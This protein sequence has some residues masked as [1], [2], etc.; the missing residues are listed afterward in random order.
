MSGPAYVFL[1]PS[2][3]PRTRSRFSNQYRTDTCPMRFSPDGGDKYCM[4]ILRFC[5]ILSMWLSP[6]CPQVAVWSSFTE[7]HTATSFRLLPPNSLFRT[8]HP[9]IGTK[10]RPRSSPP[11]HILL[12]PIPCLFPGEQHNLPGFFAMRSPN[13]RLHDDFF[14][15]FV[16][17]SLLF[18]G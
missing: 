18:Q 9:P 17:L 1:R 5:P 13:L 8:L 10:S 12:L 3:F 4:V 14:R 7:A 2:D 16:F 11:L 6:S 15:F